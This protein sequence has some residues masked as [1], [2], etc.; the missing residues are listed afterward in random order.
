MQPP[1]TGEP[2]LDGDVLTDRL[3]DGDVLA[4]R[5]GEAEVDGDRDAEAEVDGV[6]VPPVKITSLHR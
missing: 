6:A 1:G 5:D 4:D 3:A 2:G